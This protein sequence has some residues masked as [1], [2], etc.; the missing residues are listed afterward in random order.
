MDMFTIWSMTMPGL[1]LLRKQSQARDGRG[2]PCKI[3][4]KH[5]IHGRR[6]PMDFKAFASF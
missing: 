6:I 2:F 3:S 1:Y 4:K 5:L